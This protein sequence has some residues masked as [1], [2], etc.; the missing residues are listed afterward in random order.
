MAMNQR[1][2]TTLRSLL[3]RQAMPRSILGDKMGSMLVSRSKTLATVLILGSPAARLT[4]IMANPL[5][6][7]FVLH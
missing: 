5:S 1:S 2:S 7:P 6:V 3:Q 4:L